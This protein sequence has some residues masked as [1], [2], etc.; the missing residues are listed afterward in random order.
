MSEQAIA[1]PRM[2]A[3]KFTQPK[4]EKT[5]TSGPGHVFGKF[6]TNVRLKANETR[7]LL[8]GSSNSP[9]P[10]KGFSIELKPQKMPAGT[11]VTQITAEGSTKR[12]DYVLAITNCSDRS[13]NAQIWQM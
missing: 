5:V 9:I 13:V 3:Q 10:P 2:S 7:Q 12:Y 8:I 11:L 4:T 6:V 1:E